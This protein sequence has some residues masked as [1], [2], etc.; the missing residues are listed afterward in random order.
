MKRLSAYCTLTVML[1]WAPLSTASPA[2]KNATLSAEE[3]VEDLISRM[4]LREK[5]G[6]MCQYVGLK[7]IAEAES[8]IS[9]SDLKNSD[10]HGFYPDLPLAEM[11]DLI[12]RGEV[13]SFLHVVD[14]EEANQ[15]QGYAMES[16]LGIPL[17]IGI[18]A[19]HGNGLVAGAT[20]YPTPIT[21]AAS[22]NPD[23]L[24]TASRQTAKEMRANGAHW[25]FTP[26]IDIV[27][28]PRWGRVGETFGEDTEL[29][30]RMG[31][32]TINGLQQG[33]FIGTDKVIANA[34]H[35][36]GG[37]D[38]INGL[39]IAPL[40]VSERT[41]YQDYFPPFKAAVDAGAFTVMAAHNEVNGVPSHG[42]KFLLDTVL[43]DEWGFSGFVVSDW[44]DIERLNTLHHVVPNQLEAVHLTVDAGMDMHM[45][46]PGFLEPVVALVEQ[47]RL[48]EDRIDA[49]VRPILLAKFRLGLF[50]TPYVEE[51]MADTVNF[52]P[53]HQQTAQ[54]MA[55]EGIVLLK[56]D[57]DILPLKA[58]AKVFITGP[59]A[60][61]HAQLGDWTLP[62]PEA[63]VV[64]VV[65]GMEAYADMYDLTYLDVGGQVKHLTDEHIES[66]F[67][68]AR[69]ADVSIVVVG[70]NPLR[71]D[72]EG[73]TV[74]EN[75]GRASLDLIGRQLE[76]IQAIKKA[77]KP[78]IVVLINSRPISEPWL[79]EHVEGL[80]E[81][82]EPGSFGGAAIADVLTGKVNP[83][84]KMPIT[85]PFSA[86]HIQSVYNHKPST[87]MKRYTDAPTRNLSEFGEGLSYTTF[88]YSNL[89][90]ADDELSQNQSTKATVTLTNTGKRPGT[91][92][93]QLYIRDDVSSVTRPVK[94]L[95]DFKRI[96]LQPGESRDVSFTVTPKMLAFYQLDMQ[97]GV[98][99]GTFTIMAGGSSKDDDLLRTTLSITSRW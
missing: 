70:E 24:E 44:M 37:G 43:R 93:V 38:S 56:N 29:V 6:Q 95:K 86:G 46:G 5:V 68:H 7:H 99:P 10:A 94:E 15:L 1:L 87:Y 84:G 81:A 20:I 3:R 31:L 27:R 96:S 65:E 98:E 26:N 90:L 80:L 75:V 12:R 14:A 83:S 50:D 33:D 59:N 54:A 22:F 92:V 19:I 28:D 32:A 13:G 76:L 4:T 62:Q 25:S 85:V 97:F 51:D 55:E 2:Y 42:N 58:G 66:A 53:E 74:G 18:D 77:G 48:S 71:F 34:K 17:L 23:L 60:N 36:V 35:F 39:N 67:N 78:V 49:S 8:L 41:L 52:H 21:A 57:N 61:N 47:G 11:P 40:D 64:T 73:K 45:H 30:T 88:A 16:R 9:A 69:Q 63:N 79:Y 72:R 91:E 89:R 82:W